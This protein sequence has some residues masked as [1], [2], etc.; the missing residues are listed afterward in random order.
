MAQGFNV[1]LMCDQHNDEGC[2]ETYLLRH[3]TDADVADELYAK[4][5]GAFPYGWFDVL[6]GN[7]DDFAYHPDRAWYLETMRERLAKK[8]ED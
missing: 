2:F 4:M 6:E 7:S 5:G 1:V 3:T 8:E